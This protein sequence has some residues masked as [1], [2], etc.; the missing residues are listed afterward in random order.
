M[1]EKAASPVPCKHHWVSQHQPDH[2][3]YWVRICSFCHEPDWDDLDRSIL[4]ELIRRENKRVIGYRIHGVIYH[5]EDV[6]IIRKA[7]NGPSSSPSA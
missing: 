6:I 1:S 4:Q 2:E 7:E 3:I 5:P